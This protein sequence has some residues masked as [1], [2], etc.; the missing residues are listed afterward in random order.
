V[1]SQVTAQALLESHGWVR[2]R[3]GKHKVKMEKPG[4]GPITL[5]TNKRRDYPPGLTSAIPKQAGLK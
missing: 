1:L 5:P 2:T 4:H 3:G